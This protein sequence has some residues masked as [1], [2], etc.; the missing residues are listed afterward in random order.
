[1]FLSAA[2]VAAYAPGPDGRWLAWGLGLLVAALALLAA[3]T[4]LCGG[5]QL[6]VL[7]RGLLTRGRVPGHVVRSEPEANR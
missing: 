3:V 2:T 5:C 4:G 6:Y 7:G 1:M